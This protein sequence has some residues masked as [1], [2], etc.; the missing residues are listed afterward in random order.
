MFTRNIFKLLSFAALTLGLTI[1]PAQAQVVSSGMTGT[2][3]L[4][5]G[6]PIAGATVTAVHT[7]TN[8]TFTGITGANGRFA[9]VG[10]PV[11]GPYRVTATAAGHEIEGLDGVQTSLGEAVDVELVAKEEVIKL[12]KYVAVASR[13]DLDANATGASSVL[14]NRRILALPSVSRSFTDL[15]KTNPFVSV[16]GYPQ[17]EALG[18]NNRYNT[19]TLDGA[20]INDS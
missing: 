17:V 18:M 16:R 8:T 4:P 1:S 2:V 5:D 6:K 11:G 14:S 9:F 13:S 10:M 7:P 19:I 12:E 3:A 15:I 20:K